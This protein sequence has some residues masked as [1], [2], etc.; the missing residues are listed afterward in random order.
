MQLRFI[1][2]SSG[3]NGTL[4]IRGNRQDYDDWGLSGWS[5]DQVF[6]YMSKVR[7]DDVHIPLILCR[8]LICMQAETFHSTPWFTAAEGLHGSK[9]PLH[10]APHEP[11][12][13]SNMI[14]ESYQ[15][16]G[17]PL[18]QDVF[19]TGESPHACGHALRTIYHGVRTTAADYISKGNAKSNIRIK[20]DAFVDKIILSGRD[21]NKAIGAQLQSTTGEKSLVRARKEVIVSAGAYGSPAILLRSGIGPKQETQ[22]SGIENQVDLLGVGKNLIDHPV[23]LL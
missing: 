17:F 8:D 16:K 13:I 1:G 18:I 9:G 23:S 10:V 12:P 22:K 21:R 4:A 6:K 20:T 11:C 19:S 14:L 7:S 2:G 5:G 3:C 15:S